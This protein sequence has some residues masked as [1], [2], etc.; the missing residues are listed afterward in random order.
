MT[1]KAVYAI[2]RFSLAFIFLFWQFPLYAT[3]VGSHDGNCSDY[4]GE[5]CYQ[6]IQIS[7]E[8]EGYSEFDYAYHN[9][10]H[11][12]VS[13]FSLNGSTGSIFT[14]PNHIKVTFNDNNLN[15]SIRIYTDNYTQDE[16]C[17]YG[18]YGSLEGSECGGELIPETDC[19]C[20]PDVT[21]A[22][23]SSVRMNGGLFKWFN[24]GA[25]ESVNL[26][27][28]GELSTDD[29]D[30]DGDPYDSD[31]WDEKYTKGVDTFINKGG[32]DNATNGYPTG[33]SPCYDEEDLDCNGNE[34]DGTNDSR[35]EIYTPGRDI[36]VD[37]GG[38]EC[39]ED[40]NGDG[41]ED[42]GTE[43]DID[44]I[45][46]K[47][48]DTFIDVGG[49][50]SDDD[51][52]GIDEV[53]TSGTDIF[54]VSNSTTNSRTDLGG[55]ESD[56]DLDGDGHEDDGTDDNK[57]ELYTEG[58]AGDKALNNK[59]PGASLL[60]VVQEE[61][62]DVDTDGDGITFEPYT[63]VGNSTIEGYVT[64]IHQENDTGTLS[65]CEKFNTQYAN[66]AFSIFEQGALLAAFPEC[67]P[68]NQDTNGNGEPG[69]C[70][71]DD[72]AGSDPPDGVKEYDFRQVKDGEF[73]IFLG[74]DF[75]SATAGY[76][77]AYLVIEIYTEV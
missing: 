38:E 27:P 25:E 9:C 53:Y 71:D 29:D 46:T 42:D 23:S 2:S 13:G 10:G 59:S 41:L 24:R 62:E 3:H 39:D 14:S 36:F 12:V 32:E 63:F 34:D 74:A 70:G 1:H 31:E 45:Y 51:G 26:Y 76:Y 33:N 52:D 15:R 54:N 56:E 8:V 37:V 67:A 16:V 40:A 57:D 43:D 75:R 60:W 73:V 5:D 35:D 6:A 21:C 4:P 77:W 64:D 30:K 22:S 44:E 20:Y 28:D 17:R 7:G 65:Y 69:E 72:G 50:E 48:F 19:P 49:E 66:V 58:P 55:E 11:N 18:N 47:G 68:A 61:D